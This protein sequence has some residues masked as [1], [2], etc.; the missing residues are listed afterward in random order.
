[1]N[2]IRK[3]INKKIIWVVAIIIS[4]SIIVYAQDAMLSLM[5][6]K[7]EFVLHVQILALQGGESDEIGV[8]NW[9]AK[10]KIIQPIKGK[11]RKGRKG[12]FYFNRFTFKDEKESILIEVGKE[13]IIFLKGEKG[14]F[15]FSH[16]ECLTIAHTLVDRWLGILPYNDYLIERLTK[17][18]EG[19]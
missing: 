15:R 12:N 9:W 13:Y 7:S 3:I 2:V 11:M 5:K 4:L 8:E 1:M 14:K 16:D 18:I 17:Y 10:Y 19:R 6:N